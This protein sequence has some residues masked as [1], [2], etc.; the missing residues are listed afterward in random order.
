MKFFASVALLAF[1]SC[2]S[3]PSSQSPTD[4]STPTASRDHQIKVYL[5]QRSLDEDDWSPVEDQAALQLEYSHESPDDAVGWEVGIGGSADDD[6][7]DVGFGPQD[8]TL[9]TGEFYGGVR[10]S[11]GAGNVRP[12][13]G[14]GLSFINLD[15]EVDSASED[16]SSLGLY[17]HGGVEFLLGQSFALGV[18][19]R[20]LFGSEITIAGFD[21]DADYAQLALTL[22]W[23]F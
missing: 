13:I 2:M 11:F 16:D 10:K 9:A 4:G 20:T 15:V 23:R 19:L 17:L 8:V 5:G 22:G 6:T 1:S 14:G 12:Y 18:D 7:I 3:V 21:T